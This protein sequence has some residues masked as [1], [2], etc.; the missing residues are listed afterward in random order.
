VPS[1]VVAIANAGSIAAAIQSIFYGGATAGGL[2][3]FQSFGVTAVLASPWALEL[4]LL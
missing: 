3:V 1:I 4:E 2:S